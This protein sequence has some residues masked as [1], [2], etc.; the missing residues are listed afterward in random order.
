METATWARRILAL[1]VDWFACTLVVIL[2][3]GGVD[4]WAGL[5]I[6]GELAFGTL[7]AAGFL[8]PIGALGAMWH[9]LN[10]ML[11][12]GFVSHGAY[13]DKAFFAAELFCLI[14]LAGLVYGLDASMRRY[15][16][17]PLA[18]WLMGLPDQEAARRAPAPRR[19][20]QPV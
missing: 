6:S 13:T 4:Q 16:P 18:Q 12:K 3:L 7:L 8:A 14:V 5:T 15:V 20:P 2:L 10:Y 9:N 1:F 17:A 11:M 19:Q